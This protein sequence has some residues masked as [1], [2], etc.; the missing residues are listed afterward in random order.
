MMWDDDRYY[1]GWLGLVLVMVVFWALVGAGVY[2]GARWLGRDRP[3]PDPADPV[4]EPRSE[5][6]SR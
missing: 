6:R 3:P 5:A 2:L 4:D 1:L